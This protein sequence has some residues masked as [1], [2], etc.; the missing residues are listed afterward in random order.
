MQTNGAC[1]S[2]PRSRRPVS[3]VGVCSPRACA[4]GRAKGGRGRVCEVRVPS[5]WTRP[6]KSA[7]RCGCSLPLLRWRAATRCFGPVFSH[8]KVENLPA[9][10][11]VPCKLPSRVCD[12]VQFEKGFLNMTRESRFLIFHPHPHKRAC[13]TCSTASRKSS[14]SWCLWSVHPKLNFFSRLSTKPVRGNL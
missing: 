2:A 11:R 14:V 13:S 5:G 12:H 4:Q 10:A 6:T 9:T 3:C 1:V 8:K 7:W